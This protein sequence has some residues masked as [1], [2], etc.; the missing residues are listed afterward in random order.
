MPPGV[1][2]PLAAISDLISHSFTSPG[3]DVIRS[4]HLSR[5]ISELPHRRKTSK[6]SADEDSGAVALLN[7]IVH[8]SCSTLDAP[9]APATAG[10]YKGPC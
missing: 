4:R 7:C 9:S 8:P 5:P 10:E 6:L 2:I 1:P 3:L